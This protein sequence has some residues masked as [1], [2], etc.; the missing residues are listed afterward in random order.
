M[1]LDYLWY[2]KLSAKEEGS[3]RRENGGETRGEGEREREKWEKKKEKEAKIPT[4]RPICHKS[5]A[6]NY[7]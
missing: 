4:M 1:R 2:K 5:S 7:S 3:R 6:K